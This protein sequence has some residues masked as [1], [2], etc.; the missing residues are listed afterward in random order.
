MEFKVLTSLQN[1]LFHPDVI[2]RPTLYGTKVLGQWVKS[3]LT[4]SWGW[5]NQKLR[6]PEPKSAGARSQVRPSLKPPKP[7]VKRSLRLYLPASL[8]PPD[9]LWLGLTQTVMIATPAN[10]MYVLHVKLRLFY[11]LYAFVYYSN[12]Y[13]ILFVSDCVISSSFKSV[14]K[15][16][17]D[18]A[19]SLSVTVSRVIKEL[20]ED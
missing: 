7:K 1:N 13:I 19:S 8:P 11:L 4:V 18:E 2:S 3:L 9:C 16:C 6:H 12:Q 14:I 15:C 20:D 5:E 17:L 10:W